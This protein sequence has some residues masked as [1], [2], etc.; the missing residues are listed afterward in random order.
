[1]CLWVQEKVIEAL[2]Q[3]VDLLKD[4]MQWNVCEYQVRGQF[5]LTMAHNGA[6]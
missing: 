4:Q 6:M 2:T 1:M 3:R 5:L